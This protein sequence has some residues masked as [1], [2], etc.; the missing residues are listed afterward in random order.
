[1]FLFNI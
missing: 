1:M